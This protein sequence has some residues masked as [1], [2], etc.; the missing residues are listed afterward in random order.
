M[1]KKVFDPPICSDCPGVLS[2]KNVPMRKE[3]NG[4]QN[5][6]ND[7]RRCIKCGYITDVARREEE[8]ESHKEQHD[9]GVDNRG[10]RF[11]NSTNTWE[12]KE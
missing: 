7:V 12:C 11:I 2:Y 6:L 9:R 1:I 10:A 3:Y 4:I 8:D 5:R